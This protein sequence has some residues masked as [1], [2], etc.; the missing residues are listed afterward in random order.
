MSYG[1]KMDE[2]VATTI[3]PFNRAG[4]PAFSSS[5]PEIIVAAKAALAFGMALHELCTNAVKYGAR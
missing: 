1:L 4:M 2:L 5:G 3:A